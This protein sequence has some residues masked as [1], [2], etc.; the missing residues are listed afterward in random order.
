VPLH[1]CAAERLQNLQ[2]PQG[3]LG[4][5]RELEASLQRVSVIMYHMH[6]AVGQISKVEV[7]TSACADV[8]VSACAY[9][10]VAYD[11]ECRFH[12]SVRSDF[13]CF[14]SDVDLLYYLC[15]V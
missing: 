9:L 11:L 7:S 14:S 6:D 2:G 10:Y 1:H 3:L 8:G 12:H 13:F 4:R 15:M 5:V